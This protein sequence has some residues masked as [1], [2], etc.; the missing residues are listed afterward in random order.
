MSDRWRAAQA[1]RAYVPVR[2]TIVVP[3]VRWR[4]KWVSVIDWGA[5]TQPVFDRVVEAF[6]LREN[7]D[8]PRDAYAVNGRGGDDGI[9]IHIRRDGRLT[10]VQLKYFPE[11]FSGGFKETRRAQILASF[12]SA[13][14]HRPDEWWLVVPSTLT[15]GER[16]YVIELPRRQKPKL[17]KPA[18]V[19][20]DRPKLDGLAA[21]HPDLVEC[22]KR[23]ELLEAAK[24]YNQERAV[25][26]DKDDAVARV[27]A[28]SKR[29]DTLHPDWRLDFFT[30]GDVVGTILVARHPQA[31]QRSP[32]TVSISA[33]FGPDYEDL[34]RSF[35]RAM[36]YGTPDR[37]ELP[38][39]VVSD[40]KVDG[41]AFIAHTS[42][43][44][45]VIWVPSDPDSIGKPCNLAFYND[46]GALSASFTGKTTWTGA[47]QVGASIRAL[48]FDVVTVE[49]LLPHDR[50]VGARLNIDLDVA[51]RDPA[52]VARAM[53]LL[54][55]LESVHSIGF[56]L[57][58]AELARLTTQERAAAPSDADRA[59][60]T[61]HARTA[62]DLSVVQEATHRHFPY[63]EEVDFREQVYLR[64][65]RLLLEGKCVVLPGVREITSRLN[66]TDGDGIRQLLSGDY[67]SLVVDQEN[68]GLKVF[69]HDISIGPV[70]LYAPQVSAVDAAAAREALATGTAQGRELTLR[71]RDDYGLW[72]FLPERYIDAGDGK[73]RPASLELPGFIDPPDVARPL[74]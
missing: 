64:C 71:C 32:I 65:L 55:Q 59:W 16:K 19:P 73:L 31:A 40:L 13:L 30:K 43:N 51:A 2:F 74:E 24:V 12:K 57:D 6:F 60:L 54:E 34:R 23:D 52:D 47:A 58:G 22:F 69:G 37:I 4:E 20:F 33:T 11:G 72:I 41:P 56:E 44:V 21:A 42:N 9:D 50:S 5:L 66:G 46:Q 25:L 67:L 3:A 39:S 28:L 36:S 62:A 1:V 29:A 35:E 63:P 14:K 15:P 8:L 70:R 27:A 7:S 38:A 68:F 26:V 17:S 53:A 18:V 45:K 48:F 49:F 61:T 10:I